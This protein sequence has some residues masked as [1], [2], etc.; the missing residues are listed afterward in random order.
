[1]LDLL[2]GAPTQYTELPLVSGRGVH[3]RPSLRPYPP[4]PF[5]S[6]GMR[7]AQGAV[8]K[9]TTGGERHWLARGLNRAGYIF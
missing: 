5:L 1:M 8:T 7:L 6:V 3:G 2:E 9:E 4:E